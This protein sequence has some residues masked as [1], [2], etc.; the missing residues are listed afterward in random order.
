MFEVVDQHVFPFLRTLGGDGSTY[1]HHM[2]EARFTIPTPALLARVVDMIDAVPMEVRKRLRLLV[3]LIEKQKRK[4]IYTDFED[5]IGVETAFELPGF[6]APDSYA[7]FRAKARH[8]LME[9]EDNI[10]IHKLRTNEPLTPTDLSELERMF[11]ES[12]I[13]SSGDLE[14][15]KTE[16]RGLGLFVRSLIG[17][18]RQA[19]KNA[20]GVFLAGENLRANQIQF[21]DEVVN[22]LTEHGCMEA[23]RLY[24]SP[25]T[26][27]NPQGVDGVFSSQQSGPLDLDP[28]R[29]Q[30]TRHRVSSGGEQGA[31]NFLPLPFQ[32]AV[33]AGLSRPGIPVAGIGGIALLAM[34][35]GMDPGR[36]GGLVI[37]HTTM[38]RIPV[39]RS[40]LPE[41]A[42]GSGEFSRFGGGGAEFFEGHAAK[43]A[44]MQ[45]FSF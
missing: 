43:V 32:A 2:K 18:D 15:A 13:G 41:G 29:P 26:D 40:I 24:E 7:R 12:G 3:K 4:P 22:H 36:G 34:E 11:V 8:F 25:Y 16:S 1:A 21:L 19:A 17:M 23:A 20:L 27:F 45:P 33:E 44:E 38:R 5:E 37:L 6:S 9:H 42:Q 14:K 39:S 10:A 30:A 28:G 35:I 31:R